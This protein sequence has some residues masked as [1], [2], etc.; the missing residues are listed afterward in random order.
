MSSIKVACLGDSITQGTDSYNW[1]ADLQQELLPDYEFYNFGVNGEL[2]YNNLKRI[3]KLVTLQPNFIVILVGTNDVL[4]TLSEGNTRLYKRNAALPREPDMA[5]YVD[6]LEQIIVT[7]LQ[8]TTASIALTSLPVIGEDLMDS[9]NKVVSNYNE[10]IKRL[11]QKYALHY[12]PLNEA[13]TTYLEAN[14]VAKSVVYR[15]FGWRLKVNMHFR[16]RVLKQDWE[17]Y[18][19]LNGLQVTTDTI[20]LNQVSGKMMVD[21]VAQFLKSRS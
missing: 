7:L 4:A 11:V 9:A 15:P 8:E 20:H 12:L 18:A 14:P 1:V 5:W 13:I 19:G 10:K 16:T 6:N 2:A 3:D 21:L 17:S